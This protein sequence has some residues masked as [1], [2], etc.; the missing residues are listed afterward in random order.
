MKRFLSIILALICIASG[1]VFIWS[2]DTIVQRTSQGVMAFSS[3]A[4]LVLNY[5]KS[6]N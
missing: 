3:I 6:K 1:A 4:I 5:K 2:N